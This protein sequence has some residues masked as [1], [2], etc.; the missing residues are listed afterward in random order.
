MLIL[1]KKALNSGLMMFVVL[2]WLAHTKQVLLLPLMVAFFPKSHL[3]HI[4]RQNE[5]D[6]KKKMLIRVKCE[7]LEGDQ[8]L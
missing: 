1:A 6:R 8:T 3:W 7:T 4:A 5:I 2:A